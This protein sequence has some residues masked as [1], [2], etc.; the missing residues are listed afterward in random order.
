MNRVYR[1]TCF[2]NGR[3]WGLDGHSLQFFP[4]QTKSRASAETST[5]CRESSPNIST[6]I[7]VPISTLI[8]QCDDFYSHWSMRR[9]T[10]SLITPPSYKCL[11]VCWMNVWIGILPM[12]AVQYFSW[13]K[14]NWKAAFIVKCK[15]FFHCFLTCPFPFLRSCLYP[16]DWYQNAIPRA[17]PLHELRTVQLETWKCSA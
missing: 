6:L 14:G 9:Q 1:S 12:L 5:L 11:H 10:K 13:F 17:M 15:A 8:G 4:G 3:L 7:S 16:T 2:I